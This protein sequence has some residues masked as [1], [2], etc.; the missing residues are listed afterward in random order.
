ME[1]REL[2]ALLLQLARERPRYGYRS[3]HVLVRREGLEVNHKRLYR[4]YRAEGLAV[5]RR[6]RKHL[7]RGRVPLASPVGP[8]E[9]WSLDFMSD[10]L[11]DGR[12]F[13]TLNVVDDFARECRAIQVDTVAV[14]AACGENS[15]C[16][17]DRTR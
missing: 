2:R 11:A 15:R 5:R 3:L 9:G 12:V 13:R 6:R 17:H 1:M 4:L 14:W 10:Q 7:A 16:A 8:N